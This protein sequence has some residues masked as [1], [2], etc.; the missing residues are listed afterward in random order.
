MAERKVD[1]Y[2]YGKTII[3][4]QRFV[5]AEDVVKKGYDLTARN[6]NRKEVYEYEPPVLEVSR[7]LKDVYTEAICLTA[8]ADLYTKQGENKKALRYYRQSLNS[9]REIRSKLHKGWILTEIGKIYHDL[10]GPEEKN[11]KRDSSLRTRSFHS[12]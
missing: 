11:E 5:S 12:I 2:S 9:W 10:S 1:I 4:D 8:I 6:P 7:Q 3:L